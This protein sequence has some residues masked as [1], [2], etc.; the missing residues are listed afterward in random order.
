MCGWKER[1]GRWVEREGEEE[2]CMG[3]ERG[4]AKVCRG[5]GREKERIRTEGESEERW[6]V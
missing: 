3:G 4:W 6:C 1:V 5:R 2:I